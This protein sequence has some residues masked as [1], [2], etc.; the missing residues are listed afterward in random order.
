[1][2]GLLS[3]RIAAAG[4]EDAEALTT[5]E[6]RVNRTALAHV[7]P[8]ELPYPYDDVLV[9]WTLVLADPGAT[10]LAAW[11]GGELV[12]FAAHDPGQLRHLAVSV[13]NFG[14][15][16]ADDL[17]AR[18]V[19]R[20]RRAGTRAVGLW[21]LA[22]N[23]RARRFYERHGWV[24]DGGQQECP[25]PP[26]PVELGYGLRL[27]PNAARDKVR[28][29]VVRIGVREHQHPGEADGKPV[30][31]LAAYPVRAAGHHG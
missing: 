17:Y 6:E 20:W 31:D 2:T 4:P 22:A 10:T 12:G 28:Q 19:R 26:H 24:A 11:S 25:W 5:L 21:V 15:G 8:A 18:V 1:V 3:T 27:S 23:T 13:D 9:R 16:L 29:G 7:F 14:S 30:A